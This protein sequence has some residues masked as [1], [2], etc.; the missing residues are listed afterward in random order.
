VDLRCEVWR[1]AAGP[2]RHD[3]AWQR[4]LLA[5]EPLRLRRCRRVVV[6]TTHLDEALAAAGGLVAALAHREV[7][8]DVLFATDG[9]GT[10][11]GSVESPPP[12][13]RAARAA[14]QATGYRLVG[15]SPMGLRLHRLQLPSGKVP[16][17]ETDIVAALS[18]LLGYDPDLPSAVCLA[19]WQRD[20]HPDHEAVGRAAEVVCHSY[21]TRLVRY[22]VGTW[23]WAEPDDLP[24][25]RARGVALP[26]ETARRKLE[27]LTAPP[28]AAVPP[29]APQEIFLV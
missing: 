8:V 25:E 2:N 7:V 14:R 5:V 13:V 12:R 10:L 28:P 20:G 19:P 22:L 18:E 15:V 17:G 1:A 26:V 16:D 24:W 3:P 6:V 11:D 4:A 21:R 23:G 29:S 9:D 27:A